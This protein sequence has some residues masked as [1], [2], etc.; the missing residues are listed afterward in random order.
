MFSSN[1]IR[2][3]NAAINC[4]TVSSVEHELWPEFLSTEVIAAQLKA[5]HSPCSSELAVLCNTKSVHSRRLWRPKCEEAY[6]A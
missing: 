4:I 2:K 3:D 5:T 1:A 6:L